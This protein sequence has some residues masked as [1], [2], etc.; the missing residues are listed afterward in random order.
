MWVAA[1][2]GYNYGGESSINGVDSNNKKQ[3]IGWAL[4]FSRPIGKSYRLKVAYIGVR[5]Q[6]DTGLDSD[7][8]SAGFSLLW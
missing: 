5:T 8:L 7:T 3:N 6:E 1:S 2:V 4:S